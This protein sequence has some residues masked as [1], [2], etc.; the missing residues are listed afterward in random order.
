MLRKYYHFEV[1]PQSL[2]VF[3]SMNILL[4]E[5]LNKKY[6]WLYVELILLCILQPFLFIQMSEKSLSEDK[7]VYTWRLPGNIDGELTLLD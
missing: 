2:R 5:E 1:L 3:I 6:V 7:S 4:Y